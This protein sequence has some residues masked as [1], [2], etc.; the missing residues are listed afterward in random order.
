MVQVRVGRRNGLKSTGWR[1]KTEALNFEFKTEMV[2]NDCERYNTR[3][4]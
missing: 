2:E 3:N 1:P 4:C